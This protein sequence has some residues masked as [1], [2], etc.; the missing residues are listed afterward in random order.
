MAASSNAIA[1]KMLSSVML[2]VWRETSPANAL[3]FQ[4]ILASI[5]ALTGTFSQLFSLYIFLMWIFYAVQTAGVIVLRKKEPDM[6]RPYRTWGYPVVP[7]FFILGAAAVTVNLLVQSPFRSTIG[8]G[9]MLIGLPLYAY[10]RKRI[11]TQQNSQ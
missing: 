10:W 1:A 11:P 2:N 5:M 9:V 6:A 4:G 8:I 3:I 7:I